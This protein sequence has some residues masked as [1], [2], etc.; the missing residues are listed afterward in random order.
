MV[1]F[2]RGHSLCHSLRH[3]TNTMLVVDTVADYD[4]GEDVEILGSKYQEAAAKDDA[5]RIV[6]WAG[7]GVGLIDRIQSAKVTVPSKVCLP[8]P[9]HS[10]SPSRTLSMRSMKSVCVAF[11]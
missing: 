1:S 3:E 9:S 4:R 8:L 6:V 2:G 10:Y 7:T 5:N 11:P